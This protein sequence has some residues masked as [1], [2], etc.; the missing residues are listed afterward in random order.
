MGHII[1]CEW[2][3]AMGDDSVEAFVPDAVEKYKALGHDCK[4]YIPCEADDTGLKKVEFCS[5]ELTAKSFWLTSWPKT[6]YRFLS[7]PQ[8]EYDD[9]VREVSTG[10]AWHR[11]DKYL[12][13]VGLIPHKINLRKHGPI[14]EEAHQ[15]EGYGSGDSPHPGEAPAETP[16]TGNSQSHNYTVGAKRDSETSISDHLPEWGSNLQ[17]PPRESFRD[18]GGSYVYCPSYFS[19]TS[20]TELAS[21]HS[22]GVDR[23]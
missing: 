5:H 19:N 23:V 4:Q 8:D 2:I 1:G 7:K 17:P 20:S 22:S 18:F 9:L 6:L 12:S 13:E 3:I 15:D 10:P 11:I 16:G 14:A 21:W